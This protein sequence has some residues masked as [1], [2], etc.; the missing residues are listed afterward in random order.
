MT[1]LERADR[2]KQLLDDPVVRGAFEDIRM[3]LVRQLE[4][5]PMG[6]VDTQHEVALSLQLLKRLRTTIARY[7]DEIAV[8]QHKQKQDS[9]MRRIRESFTA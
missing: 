5:V 9:F 4:E 7:T 3:A 8:D 2:A 1:P 6:D